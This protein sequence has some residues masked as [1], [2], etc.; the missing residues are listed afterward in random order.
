MCLSSIAA[1]FSQRMSSLQT[2]LSRPVPQPRAGWLGALDTFI[3]PRASPAELLL[4]FIPTLIFAFC[5]TY[6]ASYLHLLHS[7][8]QYI[9][10]VILAIDLPGG[11]LTNST[12]ACKRWYHRPGQSA[13]Q[14]L[15]FAAMHVLHILLV[16]IFFR[17]GHFSF[18]VLASMLLMASAVVIVNTPLYLKNVVAML[19]LMIAIFTDL[20]VLKPTPALE[21]FV[22]LLFLKICVEHL[23]PEI[24]S[25]SEM[26]QDASTPLI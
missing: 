20:Y 5:L 18:F 4:Q 9:L 24:T 23:V 14:H 12:Q 11:V 26:Q 6:R 19:V 16:A 7:N 8:V 10:F 13:R 25:V 2:T 17:A 1:Y 15:T 3:G 22:P 21:W